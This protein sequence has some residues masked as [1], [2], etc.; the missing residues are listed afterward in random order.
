MKPKMI[1]KKLFYIRQ[2]KTEQNDSYC[3][4]QVAFIPK[5]CGL[6]YTLDYDFKNMH[7]ITSGMLPKK[8]FSEPDLNK[9]KYKGSSHTTLIRLHITFI[10]HYFQNLAKVRRKRSKAPHCQGS[11]NLSILYIL[12][13][14]K[15]NDTHPSF[16]TVTF[17]MGKPRLE[18]IHKD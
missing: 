12:R 8:A 13:N 14:Y 4:L 9:T 11:R 10:L 18:V 1:K 7:C 2:N 6:H 17:T 16:Y 5:Y 15:G 3:M